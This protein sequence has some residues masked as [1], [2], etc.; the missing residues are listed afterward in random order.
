[1]A[2]KKNQLQEQEWSYFF[3]V[4]DLGDKPVDITIEADDEERK[5]LISRLNV[6]DIQSVKADLTLLREQAGRVVRASGQ[7]TANIIQECS[8]TTEPIETEIVEPFDGWFADKEGTVS[9]LAAKREREAEQSV[10]GPHGEVEILSEEDDPE[11]IVDG[12]IDLGELVTQYLSLAIP[13]YPHKDGA[14]HDLTDDDFDAE[15]QSALKKNP[16]EALK[17]WKENR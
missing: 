17:D 10:G 2:K 1:M 7:L 4:E 3:D 5:N 14:V 6:Q 12:H 9:F 11:P 8:V 16:F 15:D 13:Q